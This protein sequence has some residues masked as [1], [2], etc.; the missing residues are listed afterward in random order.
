M[1]GI[2]HIDKSGFRATGLV[3][4]DAEQIL[5]RLDTQMHTPINLPPQGTSHSSQAS[6]ATAAPHN[7][8]WVAY[9]GSLHRGVVEQPEERPQKRV[10]R[11]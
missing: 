3:P 7:N 9:E 10:A 5:S 6:W 11:Q 8:G 4:Y 1:L 2:N